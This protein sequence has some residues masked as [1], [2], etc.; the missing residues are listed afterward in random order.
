MT[1]QDQARQFPFDLPMAL[2]EEPR[3]AALRR[4]EPVVRIALPFGGEGWLVTRHEDVKAVLS[5]P[6]FC[7]AKA[8]GREDMPR[9]TPEPM[10]SG[11]ILAMDAPE[12]TR[13][14]RLTTKAFAARSVEKMRSDIQGTIDALLD[15]MEKDGRPGDIV[16]HLAQPLPLSV[17]CRLLGVPV[18][19]EP[20]FRRF[21]DTALSTG[22]HS[23]EQIVEARN[24]ALGYLVELIG[25][26]RAEPSDDLLGALIEAR[27]EGDRLS[28]EELINFAATLLFAGYEST[29]NQIA[30]FIYV[31]MTQRE[32]WERLLADPELVP[33][34]VEEL[35]RYIP[36]AS[37]GTFS[38]VAN[39]DL[40]LSGVR[41]KAGDAVF[42]SHS[43]ANRDEDVF[44]NADKV[45][46][47]REQN[48]HLAFGHGAHFCLGAQ[49][50]RLEL[51]LALSSLLKRYPGLSLAVPAD[52]V[53]WKIGLFQRGPVGL[54]V[55]W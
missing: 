6:R 9:V 33:S 18:E 26:R 32:H 31:L 54:P 19:A 22:A 51:Q 17:I 16:T 14:R 44:P 3:Y 50:G 24:I 5:D 35:L 39:E 45:D 52:E 46:L 30:N 40:E 20:R 27:D 42:A 49:L 34:A 8:F 10:P 37:E 43:S 36:L 55:R 15:Q 4:D 23:R 13:L 1:S 12:H 53:V 41:I 47:A 2:D 21:T 38:A 25:R 48:P 7:R 29:S 11:N 28:E